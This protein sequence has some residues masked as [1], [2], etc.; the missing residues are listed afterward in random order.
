[1]SIA[2]DR[3]LGSAKTMKVS[4]LGKETEI[5]AGPFVVATSYGLDVLEISVMK[6]KHNRYRIYVT[7]LSYDKRATKTEK[8]NQLVHSYINELENRIRQY[9]IQWYNY[10]DFW[11]DVEA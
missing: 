4:L 8:Q 5:P 2:G 7:P 11:K 10:Y 9:P 3:I 1:M 6:V